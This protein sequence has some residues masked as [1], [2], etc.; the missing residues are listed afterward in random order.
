MQRIGALYAI[1]D[2]IRGQPPEVRRAVRQARAG[3]CSM[4]CISGSET[5]HGLSRKSALGGAIS[6]R[7]NCGRR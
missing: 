5:L 6:M 4:T 3:R 1:E 2:E 7:W